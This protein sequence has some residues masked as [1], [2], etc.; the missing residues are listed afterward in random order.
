MKTLR[1]GIATYEEMKARSMA[2]V[3]G[4]L[5][6]S[7]DAPRVWFTS[8]ES[9]AKVLSRGNQDLLRLIR[10]HEP[11]SL[12]ELATLS[13]RKKSNLSRTLKTM[14]SYGLVELQQGEKR[15]LVPKVLY[16]SVRLDLALTDDIEDAPENNRNAVLA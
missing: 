11:R 2:L 3:R 8:V 7:S 6:R 4:E 16:E 12:D 14:E 9:F 5:K 13:R 10:E 15:R 1:V